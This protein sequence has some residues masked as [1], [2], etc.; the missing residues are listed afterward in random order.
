[1]ILVLKLCHD[2]TVACT[3]KRCREEKARYCKDH[4]ELCDDPECQ[5]DD[6][7]FVPLLWSRAFLPSHVPPSQFQLSLCEIHGARNRTIIFFTLP[8][9][10]VLLRVILYQ[11]LSNVFKTAKVGNIV[12]YHFVKSHCCYCNFHDIFP[13]TSPNLANSKLTVGSLNSIPYGSYV[14]RTTQEDKNSK[15]HGWSL[16]K[17]D[18]SLRILSTLSSNIVF[19]LSDLIPY[20][21]RTSWCYTFGCIN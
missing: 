18:G 4:A 10:W 17:Y 20:F 1:M 19:E 9:I 5:R 14:R 3:R 2:H 15:C 13:G 7:W 12:Y 8:E 6:A 16:S 21:C 11:R